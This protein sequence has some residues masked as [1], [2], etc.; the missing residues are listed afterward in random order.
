M[1][2]NSG[3]ALLGDLETMILSI[4]EEGETHGLE[5]VRRLE[6]AGCELLRRKEGLLYPALYRLETRGLI[7]SV[8]EEESRGCCGARR[9]FYRLT[10]KGSR[11]L[12]AGREEWVV[13]TRTIGGILGAPA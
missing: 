8:W 6:G 12:N 1:S 2:K 5:I 13:F 3:D 7:K 9:R 10:S 4:L 11:A